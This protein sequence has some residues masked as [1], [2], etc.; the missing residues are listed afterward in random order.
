MSRFRIPELV[1]GSLLTI[2]VFAMGFLFA[3]RPDAEET[4]RDI[5]KEGAAKTIESATNP[6][7]ELTGPTWLTKDAAG[8]F[9]FGLVLVGG[10]QAVMFLIQ[11][12]Y[13][14]KGMNDA[15]IAANA[16]KDSAR[17]AAEANRPWVSI[18]EV[19][20]TEPFRILPDGVVSSVEVKTENVGR[21]P[22]VG[23]SVWVQ[24]I[25]VEF[26]NGPDIRQIQEMVL[27]EARVRADRAFAG[28]IFPSQITLHDITFSV[29]RAQL[30]NA[31]FRKDN[32][33]DRVSFMLGVCV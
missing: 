12:R 20:F 26:G 6:D 19:S 31:I 5:S 10:F 7:K 11:L 2:A 33:P 23:V 3:C 22:A 29:T 18:K 30:E 4:R 16:A 9:T 28:S 21:S 25:P 1:L 17:A 27:N 32:E 24:L 15:T 14:R 13:M 8:F